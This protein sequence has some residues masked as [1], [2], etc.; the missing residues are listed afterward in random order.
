[1]N[2]T[3][4]SSTLPSAFKAFNAWRKYKSRKT[5]KPMNEWKRK[6]LPRSIWC[7]TKTVFDQ[8]KVFNKPIMSKR[9]YVKAADKP[10]AAPKRKYVKKAPFSLLNI[11][12]ELERN[13]TD[14]PVVAIKERA[15]K[16]LTALKAE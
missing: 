13:M 10:P 16:L 11:I 8:R 5:T 7:G 9:K 14:E 4:E 2:F 3:P 15:M 6:G 1:M 12:E